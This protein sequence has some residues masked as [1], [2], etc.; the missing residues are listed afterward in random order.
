MS[1]FAPSDL[2]YDRELLSTL[3]AYV[4]GA[5]RD[6][7]EQAVSESSET[8]MNLMKEGLRTKDA[9]LV[10]GCFFTMLA[11]H[12]RADAERDTRNWAAQ[13]EDDNEAMARRRAL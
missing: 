11:A 13:V 3:S 12:Y 9:T 8:T 7:I 2:E 4:E 6:H 1:A 5:D 10:G